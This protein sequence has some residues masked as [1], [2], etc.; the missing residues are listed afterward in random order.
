MR[1]R[2]RILVA[3]QLHTAY[4]A[5]NAGELRVSQLHVRTPTAENDRKG[6]EAFAFLSFHLIGKRPSCQTRFTR[7]FFR[8]R[9]TYRPL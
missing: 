9:L 3:S 1:Q 8:S 4:N 5:C 7:H 6:R 2:L